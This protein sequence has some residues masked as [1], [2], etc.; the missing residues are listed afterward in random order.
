MR[1]GDDRE[2]T[3]IPPA[4]DNRRTTAP[5]V[6]FTPC[7]DHPGDL[8]E[9]G[10]EGSDGCL[11]L[12]AASHLAAFLSGQM[13]RDELLAQ[14][15]CEHNRCDRCRVWTLALPLWLTRH[16]A[17]TLCEDCRQDTTDSLPRAA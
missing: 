5:A 4:D 14:S 15:G 8:D 3:M 13:S 16:E 12:V 10:F 1:K 7:R 6:T 17:A 11:Y 9:L 2:R